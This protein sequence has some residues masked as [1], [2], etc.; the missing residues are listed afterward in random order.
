MPFFPRVLIHLVGFDHGV[1]QGV[2]VHPKS[3]VALEPVPQLK[4]VLAVAPQLAG[5]PGRGGRLGDAAE[6]QHQ[7]GRR[8]PDA[9]QGCPGEGVEDAPAVAAL[10][11]EDRVAMAA[12][13]TE[14]VGGA[15]ARAGQAAGVQ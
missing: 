11:I 5:H 3:G 15:A 14:A 8:P 10:V 1:A 2:A 12:V 9:L 13:D 7:L 6:D 4:Q